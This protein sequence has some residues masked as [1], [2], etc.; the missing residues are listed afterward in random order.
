M[1]VEINYGS[2][3][4]EPGECFEAG[5]YGS[6]TFTDNGQ[7]IS[8]KEPLIYDKSNIEEYAAQF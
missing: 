6:F 4:F 5:D 8:L 7:I 3:T 2:L 1:S